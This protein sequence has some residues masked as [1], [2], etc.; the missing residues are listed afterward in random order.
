MKT[1]STISNASG[2]KVWIKCQIMKWSQPFSQA[3]KELET[4][5][6]KVEL[7]SCN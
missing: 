5:R 4:T 1:N 2:N 3:K 7:F 6:E